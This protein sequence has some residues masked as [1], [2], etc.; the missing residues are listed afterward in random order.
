MQTVASMSWIEKKA[1]R[2][3]E[4]GTYSMIQE[5]MNG[6]IEAMS[7]EM[8]F[9][10]AQKNDVFAINMLSESI[11][12]IGKGISYILNLLNPEVV[13]L[14]GEMITDDDYFADHIAY[15]AKKNSLYMIANS[16]KFKKT[17]FGMKIGALALRRK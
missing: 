4:N 10:A 13:I 3:L 6:N 17:R 15:E 11:R 1:R 2:A 7:V 14:A 12:Y 16:V 5:W 9:H 8:L